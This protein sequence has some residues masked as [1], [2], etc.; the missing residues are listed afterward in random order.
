MRN[1]KKEVVRIIKLPFLYIVL[2]FNT[3]SVEKYLK[4][5]LC[6]EKEEFFIFIVYYRC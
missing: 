5:N 2:I 3:I 6:T 4:N 1:E